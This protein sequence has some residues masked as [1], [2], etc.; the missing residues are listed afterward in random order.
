MEDDA[1]GETVA[2]GRSQASQALE[3]PGAHRGAR[4]DFDPDDCAGGSLQH[5]VDFDLVFVAVI[6]DGQFLVGKSGRL[7]ELGVD[8]AFQKGPQ[9]GLSGWAP[10]RELAEEVGFEPTVPFRTQR[11]SRPPP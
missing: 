5:E 9:F 4:F 10:E 7:G 6:T 11:F 3:V 2:D 1:A 8:E